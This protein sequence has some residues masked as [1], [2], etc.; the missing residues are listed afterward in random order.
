MLTTESRSAICQTGQSVSCAG[1]AMHRTTGQDILLRNVPPQWCSQAL[2]SR[3][4]HG[5]VVRR[6]QPH[7]CQSALCQRSTPQPIALAPSRCSHCRRRCSGICK[8]AALAEEAEIAIRSPDAGTEFTCINRQEDLIPRLPSARLKRLAPGPS[9]VTWKAWPLEQT[10][11]AY[12]CPYVLEFPA[13]PA[14]LWSAAAP[15]L[16]IAQRPQ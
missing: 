10:G 9:R 7:C 13:T 14:L 3:C 6:A 16:Q 15:A 12:S 5:S 11:R 2:R 8:A 1:L 4:R